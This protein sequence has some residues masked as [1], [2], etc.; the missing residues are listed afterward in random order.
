MDKER[1][2]LGCKQHLM[3][4]KG[5]FDPVDGIILEKKVYKKEKRRGERFSSLSG[6]S[7]Q[8]STAEYFSDVVDLEMS[9]L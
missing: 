4:S 1:Y 8:I 3:E 9:S 7:S 2:F 6:L 5:V